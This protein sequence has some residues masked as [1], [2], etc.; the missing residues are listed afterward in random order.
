MVG[1]E[2]DIVIDIVIGIAVAFD[3]AVGISTLKWR[4][5]NYE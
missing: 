1:R 2:V 5:P 4:S 3:V